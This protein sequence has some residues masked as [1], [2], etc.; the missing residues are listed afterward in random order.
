MVEHP[1]I[2]DDEFIELGQAMLALI[3]QAH[4]DIEKAY[5][6]RQYMYA[7]FTPEQVDHICYTIGDWYLQWKDKLLIRGGG[8]L[9]ALGAAKEE[10][11]VMICG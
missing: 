2:M 3:A 4:P 5:E 6:E 1:M 10:L 8:N 9:H 7:S 11:K